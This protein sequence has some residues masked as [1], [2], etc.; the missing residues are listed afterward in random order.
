LRRAGAIALPIIA[1]V[2]LVSNILWTQQ[3]VHRIRYVTLSAL[4]FV[5]DPSVDNRAFKAA[6]VPGLMVTV[7]PAA[8]TLEKGFFGSP[9][10]LAAKRIGQSMPAVNAQRHCEGVMT[11]I[12][13]YRAPA[14]RAF[15]GWAVPPDGDIAY[16][17]VYADGVLKGV[18]MKT[19]TA[20][21]LNASEINRRPLVAKLIG[22]VP[23]FAPAFGVG[24]AFLAMAK[25]P[26]GAAPAEPVFVC[27][28][29]NG[30][31]LLLQRPPAP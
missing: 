12:E 31:R 16:L 27:V 18:G 22:K 14:S 29:A 2:F 9:M 6:F 4:S 3:S 17:E 15:D 25:S 19:G 1:A 20:R 28:L 24:P 26:P 30:D 13:S 11:E 8:V 7:V 10:A 21:P 5:V 23:L